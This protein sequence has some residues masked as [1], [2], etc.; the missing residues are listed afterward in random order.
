MNSSFN[1]AFFLHSMKLNRKKTF[2]SIVAIL[3][4]LLG[5]AIYS[6]FRPPPVILKNIYAFIGLESAIEN[7]RIQL[8]E[9][10]L[11]EWFLYNFPDGLWMLSLSLC[12]LLIWDLGFSRKSI[13]WIILCLCIGF[14]FEL[15]QAIK[16]VQG[17][18][19][20]LD[21]L[22]ISFGFFLALTFTLK[23]K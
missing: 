16:I 5:T 20:P 4:L 9:I 7:I 10:A 13:F 23:K 22:F 14:G 2:A 12:I 11:P 1:K 18:F 21:L 17:I 6:F 3:S 15:L 8:T 19:D